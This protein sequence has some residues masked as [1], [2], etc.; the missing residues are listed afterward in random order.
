MDGWLRGGR[1]AGAVDSLENR[2]LAWSQAAPL[3]IEKSQSHVHGPGI[4]SAAA[5]GGNIN[6]VQT[7]GSKVVACKCRS[8]GQQCGQDLGKNSGN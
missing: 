2:R 1:R 7:P 6:D 4:T 8:R 3:G 5:R